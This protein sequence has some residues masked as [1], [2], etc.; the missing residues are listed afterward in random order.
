MEDKNI[1]QKQFWSGAGGDVWVDK[2]REM[3]IMLN[4]LG[5]RAIQGLD[6]SGEIKIL[7]IGCGCGATTLEIAKAVTQGEVIGVDISEP[8][9]ER[10]T[11]TASDMMLNNT[12]FQ[13]K[14]VQVDEMP[15][16]YFD[17]AFSRF[18]VMF[19]EDPFEAF[20]NINHSLKD[21][22]QLSFV[23]W[24]HASLNPWQS[25]SIQVI[26]EFLDLPAPAPKSPGPFAFEDK[27]YINEILT[28][29]GFRDIEIKDNQE[30]IVMFSGKSI[31]EACED[32]LTINPVVTEMLKNSPTELREEILE[33]LIG[34]FSDFH[35]N[36]G[37]LFPSATWIVTAKK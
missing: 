30:D 4:P 19:F 28:E 3:D 25:L 21:N 34:K 15:L 32:Y 13:V 7:D 18:G 14:D 16:S 20:K 10:A 29:S 26:K 2:Q 12:S 1:K 8:M 5:E 31:R 9:L 35:N 36:E 22:G 17:I 27:N 33:A 23:C 11:K 6:L 24:Q 37:L